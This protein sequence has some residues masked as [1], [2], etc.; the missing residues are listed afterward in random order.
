ML[1][2]AH[3]LSFCHKVK[4]QCCLLLADAS[5]ASLCTVSQAS[6]SMAVHGPT[7]LICVW[8]GFRTSNPSTLQFGPSPLGQPFLQV[9]KRSDV[10]PAECD[11]W[12]SLGSHPLLFTNCWN[13][14]L[15]QGYL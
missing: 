15:I 1:K 5:E 9:C 4:A 12:G 7:K 13:G 2:D 8:R 6:C 14:V 3:W 11:Q 10:R